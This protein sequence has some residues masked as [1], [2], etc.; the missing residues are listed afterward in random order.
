MSLCPCQSAKEFDLCCGPYLAGEQLPPTAEALM[1]SR[2]VAYARKEFD[3]VVNTWHVSNRPA[4]TDFGEHG[5]LTWTGLEIRDTEAGGPDDTEG[6]VEFVARCDARGVTNVLHEKSFFRKEDDRWFYLDGEVIQQQPVRSL[7]VG[8][9]E[10]CPCGSG[11]K[12]KKCCLAK[13]Q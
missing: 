12:H 3:Y 1:R 4:A 11:R 13:S 6:T 7:K 10:P 5:R 8:R 2:Y 9:N